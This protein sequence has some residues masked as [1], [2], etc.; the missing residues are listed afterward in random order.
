MGISRIGG[1]GT[2]RPFRRVTHPTRGRDG[3]Q[4]FP[5]GRR[6]ATD[7]SEPARRVADVD[8]LA[9]NA[10]PRER[11]A[12]VPDPAEP[13]RSKG[14]SDERLL[15]GRHPRGHAARHGDTR[16]RRTLPVLND[17]TPDPGGR[18]EWCR[19][20]LLVQDDDTHAALMTMIGQHAKRGVRTYQTA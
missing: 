5:G 16:R 13:I 17:W 1:G 7:A 9:P 11:P 10:V 6:Q 4:P 15:L 2:P 3:G 18:R 19:R 12:C 20:D 14:R 8:I